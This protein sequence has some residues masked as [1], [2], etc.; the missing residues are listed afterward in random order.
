MKGTERLN[1]NYVCQSLT[2]KITVNC[3]C[4]EV[5]PVYLCIID[6]KTIISFKH[7]CFLFLCNMH[8]MYSVY[9]TV[10]LYH[11]KLFLVHKFF[12]PLLCIIDLSLFTLK[13][14]SNINDVFI[15]NIHSLSSNSV[16][17]FILQ[18]LQNTNKS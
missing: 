12:F 2:L 6:R 14:R 10:S 8:N 17:A 5:M 13:L 7:A 11:A 15:S 18:I 4:Y 1:L 16:N 3:S 9:V